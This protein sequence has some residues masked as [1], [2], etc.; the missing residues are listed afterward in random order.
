MYTTSHLI[1]PKLN[2]NKPSDFQN[3]LHTNGR[4]AKLVHFKNKTKTKKN[5]EQQRKKLTWTF[6]II[7]IIFK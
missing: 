4:L 3:C 5:A 6:T 1:L 2:Q 7:S